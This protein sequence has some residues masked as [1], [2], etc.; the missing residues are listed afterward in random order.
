MNPILEKYNEVNAFGRLI[1]MKLKVIKP[2]E[3]EY[4]MKITENHL[5]NPFAAHGGAIS[6]LMDGILGV[7][8]L[9]LS[10][11]EHKL[12]STVEFKLNYYLPILPGDELLGHGKVTFAGNRLIFS[13]GTIYAEN[14]NNTVV[15]KGLG[16][17]NAYPADKNDL[18]KG[19]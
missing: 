6:S 2:G 7:S 9:S 17:F 14:R 8:A 10:V 3:V 11:E 12:V 1:G 16:T 18:F 13:E 15:C 19:I 4:R 5:S